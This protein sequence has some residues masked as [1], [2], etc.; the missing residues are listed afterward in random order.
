MTTAD[1]SPAQ[2]RRHCSLPA[3]FRAADHGHRPPA[4]RP[5]RA[6]QS[7]NAG[8]SSRQR[9]GQAGGARRDHL[10]QAGDRGGDH[11]QVGICLRIANGDQAGSGLGDSAQNDR[12]ARLLQELCDVNPLRSE[13][14]PSSDGPPPR[15]G[16]GGRQDAGPRKAVEHPCQVGGDAAAELRVDLAIEQV[17]PGQPEVA[18]GGL[19]ALESN[20]GRRLPAFGRDSQ[21]DGASAGDVRP[22]TYLDGAERKEG[23]GRVG[24]AGEVVRD[25]AD[26]SQLN[27]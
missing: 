5:A 2:P 7:T 16:Q 3:R 24:S 27:I 11:V 15:L 19:G 14:L 9:R 6:A 20:L 4:G 21:A 10:G 25:E 22:E 12:T 26:S 17:T 18:S 1:H 13:Q 8:E 23:D